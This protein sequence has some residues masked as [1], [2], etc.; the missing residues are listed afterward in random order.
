MCGIV[1]Y[2][3]SENQF[4]L[5]ILSHRGPDFSNI[6]QDKSVLLGHTR[7]SILDV[8]NSS[9][10]P[11]TSDDK[12]YILVY[13]G[14]LY[15]HLDIRN[16]LALSCND[17]I[18]FKT[19][20]DTETVLHALINWGTNA[21]SRFNGIFALAFYDRL[22][23]R[24]I[25]ARDRF[26]V[27][28][29]YYGHKCNSFVFSSELK[30]LMNWEHYD[31]E[32]SLKALENY[33][34]FLWSPG[35]ETPLKCIHKLLPG[36]FIDICLGQNKLDVKF[37]K[38]FTMSPMKKIISD[39]GAIV[40]EL[41]MHLRTAVKRQLL[42][43]V[44]VGFFLSGG[45]DSSLI[46]AIAR[47]LFP[48]KKIT[49]FTIDTSEFSSTEGFSDDLHYAQ[50]VAEHL[51]VELVVVKA[52]RDI[53]KNFDEMVW[54]LDEPQ[55]DAAPLNV[56][57]ISKEARKR[58]FKVLIGGTAGDDLFTGYRRHQVFNALKISRLLPGWVP[59]GIECVL[60]KVPFSPNKKRRLKK[61]LRSLSEVG[62]K[63]IYSLF[64]WIPFAL[65]T[66][67]F[68]GKVKFVRF[69]FFNKLFPQTSLKKFSLDDLLMLE[70]ASFLVDH[71]LNYT[72]KMGMAVGVEIRVP[73]LDNDLE[74]F[75][76][77]IPITLMMKDGVTKYILKKTAEKYLPK[78]VI[79][80]KKSG[81]GAPIRKWITKDM[82]H[83]IEDDLNPSKLSE[84]GIFDSEKVQKL[85]EDNHSGKIDASYS[86]WALL[87]IQSWIKQFSSK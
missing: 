68:S 10:Q 18:S 59:L 1:G 39:E 31:S 35:I 82:K 9:N 43:D 46:V 73:F 12:R 55:A 70:K 62:E 58:G 83:R 11:F 20:S 6:Y 63:K 72:D 77:K 80:R 26:G 36:E 57:N 30:A 16:D 23:E 5:S 33:I 52:D 47:D 71:N 41:D 69:E 4:D 15:N 65:S 3:Y 53:L 25:I 67:L 34:R 17:Q 78:E 28:P 37:E 45:L 49:C 50:L 76:R 74:L 8:S 86:I 54:F 75:T 79:Y 14:E 60:S 61:L 21:L 44:P 42:S 66:S 85:I 29:L 64:E 19:T 51:N 27:K 40:L 32:L 38:Y 22:E 2:I 48:Q 24:L 13:N 56:F 87:A 7:L 81:F 84:Q